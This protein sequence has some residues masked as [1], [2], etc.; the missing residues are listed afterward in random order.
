MW[1]LR[2]LSLFGSISLMSVCK[3]QGPRALSFGRVSVNWLFGYH[4][5]FASCRGLKEVPESLQGGLQGLYCPVE[6]E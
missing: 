2:H 6:C 4:G 3:E 1:K 5:R